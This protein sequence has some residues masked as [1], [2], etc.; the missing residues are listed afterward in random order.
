MDN[1]LNFIREKTR[2]FEPEIAVILGSGLGDYTKGL[3]GIEIPYGE[4]EGFMPS[5]VKGHK[6]SLFF[7]VIKN[8]KVVIMQG[9][10]HFYEGYPMKSITFPVR[11]FKKLGVKD[12][13]DPFMTLSFISLPVIPSLRLTTRGLVRV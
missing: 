4:I 5:S 10:F 7:G 8:K 12:G 9:R 6:G 11:V 13:I 1:T 3:D 2:G